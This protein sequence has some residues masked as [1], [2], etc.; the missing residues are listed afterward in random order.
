MW[1]SRCCLRV[2]SQAQIDRLPVGEKRLVKDTIRIMSLLFSY[3][4]SQYPHP[5]ESVAA[6]FA[7]VE[8]RHYEYVLYDA[9]AQHYLNQDRYRDSAKVYQAFTDI[10]GDHFQAPIFAV[11]QIDS[12]ILGQFP[13]LVLPAKQ[14]FCNALWY[15]R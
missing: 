10:H 2:D 5:A 9:L 4:D 3:Q 8:N 14:A 11:K 13:T 15:C 12:Y 6:H 1:L 7:Q